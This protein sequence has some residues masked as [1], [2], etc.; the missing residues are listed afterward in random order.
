MSAD[1]IEL[2]LSFEASRIAEIRDGVDELAAAGREEDARLDELERQ[3]GG[4]GRILA[5][6]DTTGKRED[7][8]TEY[9]QLGWDELVASA[10]MNLAARGVDAGRGRPWRVDGCR[11]DR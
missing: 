11:R 1:D 6:I 2:V 7:R 9:V 8:T 10:R 4:S 5:A 3:L